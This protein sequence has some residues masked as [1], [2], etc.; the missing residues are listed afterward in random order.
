MSGDADRLHSLLTLGSQSCWVYP[1][2]PLGLGPL[3]PF[4]K[5]ALRKIKTLL[6]M[7]DMALCYVSLRKTYWLIKLAYVV[8]SNNY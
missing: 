1:L 4:V 2:A 3:G 5:E 7:Y 6:A 8:Y